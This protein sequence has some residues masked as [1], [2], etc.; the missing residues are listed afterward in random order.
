MKRDVAAN[1]GCPE[2]DSEM[3]MEGSV[4][5]CLDEMESQISDL[6]DRL[7]QVMSISVVARRNLK[8]TLSC[9][10][11]VE[12]VLAGIFR[13]IETIAGSR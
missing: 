3:R 6:S 2:L 11:C 5:E 10:C 4:I 7:H 1:N 8:E 9:S 13:A 12:G